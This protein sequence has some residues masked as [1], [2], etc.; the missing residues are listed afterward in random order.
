MDILDI[1]KWLVLLSIPVNIAL[2][3]SQMRL[4]A[5]IAELKVWIFLNFERAGK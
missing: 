4:R 5:E 3:W 1:N 2:A